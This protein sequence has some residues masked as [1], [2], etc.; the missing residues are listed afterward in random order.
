MLCD[1]QPQWAPTIVCIP[2]SKGTTTPKR[3][4]TKALNKIARANKAALVRF[5]PA[6]GKAIFALD[7]LLD[8]LYLLLLFF[9]YIHTV[10]R[11][12]LTSFSIYP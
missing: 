2:E 3:L 9:Q 6:A 11:Q 12:P 8:G 5:L 1:V 4:L 7:A 10:L